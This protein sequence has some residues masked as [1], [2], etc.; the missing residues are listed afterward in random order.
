VVIDALAV[1][2]GAYL[3]LWAKRSEVAHVIELFRE[4]GCEPQIVS[5]APFAWPSLPGVHNDCA[6]C[7]GTALGII[8]EGRLSYLRALDG[9][10][11]HKQLQASLSALDL[12]N[13]RLPQRLMLFG[14]EAVTL[15]GMDN[16]PL[17]AE[18]LQLPDDLAMILW[19]VPV[20]PVGCRISGEVTWPGQPVMPGCAK[21]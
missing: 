2:D 1:G 20:M 13:G 17:A 15:A 19:P 16:L 9:A 3:A 21:N 5:S 4:A 18:Q 6:I 8:A 11:P 12:A 7:D 14:E 10:Q